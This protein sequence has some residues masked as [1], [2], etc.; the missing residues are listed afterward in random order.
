MSYSDKGELF[1]VKKFESECK[2]REALKILNILEDREGPTIQEQLEIHHLKSSLLFELG[3][4]TKALNY[5]ELAYRESRQLKNKFQIVDVLLTKIKI[6]SK[7][8]KQNQALR[9]IKT[10]EK[11]L[12]S[13]NQ[14]SSTEFKEK[15]A[16]LMLCKGGYYFNMGELNRSL[17]YADEALNI[18]EKI[19]DKK[20]FMLATKLRNFN[21]YYKGELFHS[22]ESIKT[23]LALAEELGDKQEIIGGL[24][25][26]GMFF[27]EKGDFKKALSYLER[28]LLLCDDINSFKTTVILSSLFDVYINMNS[29]E[30]AE[31]CLERMKQLASQT[32]FDLDGSFY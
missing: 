25:S 15:E 8:D 26:I 5:A 18:A 10:T 23:Y 31:Q 32:Q 30:N 2:Y 24:N 1:Q 13:I 20:L 21:N 28:G 3:Y 9:A 11:L 7:S 29:L 4:M 27:T 14:K 22:L 19:K 17:K 6:L 12:R 16:Y